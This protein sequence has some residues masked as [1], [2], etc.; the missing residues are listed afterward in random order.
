MQQKADNI[1]IIVEESDGESHESD[2]DV[3]PELHGVE[4]ITILVESDDDSRGIESGLEDTDENSSQHSSYIDDYPDLEEVPVNKTKKRSKGISEFIGRG[5][6]RSRVSD[7]DSPKASKKLSTHKG[8][9]STAAKASTLTFMH[10]VI[11]AGPKLTTNPCFVPGC[12]LPKSKKVYFFRVP[13]NKILFQ[14]WDILIKRPGV[15]LTGQCLVCEQHFH[16]DDI[17]TVRSPKQSGG[18]CLYQPHLALKKEA[19][20]CINYVQRCPVINCGLRAGP[21]QQFPI[22]EKNN[23]AVWLERLGNPRLKFEDI[24]HI[25]RYRICNGHFRKKCFDENGELKSGSAPTE[26]IPDFPPK[27]YMSYPSARDLVTLPTPPLTGRC[28]FDKCADKAKKKQKVY[29]LPST[30]ESVVKWLASTGH[31]N[32]IC[33]NLEKTVERVKQ[34]VSDGFGVCLDHFTSYDF[35]DA[36][37]KELANTAVPTRKGDQEISIN[38]A[39]EVKNVVPVPSSAAIA[40]PPVSPVNNNMLILLPNSATTTVA[41][42]ITPVSL[43]LP[44]NPSPQQTKS[45]VE[46]TP[47]TPILPPPLATPANMVPLLVSNNG[48][49]K[50][51]ETIS[52]R[53]HRTHLAWSIALY[54]NTKR[55]ATLSTRSHQ[56]R[57]ATHSVRA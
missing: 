33:T 32:W 6:K 57:F 15:R 52:P 4:D 29:P 43:V 9:T 22:L 31:P 40:P 36:S 34:Q 56:T 1:E 11:F 21:S 7:D 37:L 13:R 41:P 3:E 5:T 42:P 20:P 30:F 14:L 27:A 19:L 50:V 39:V 51:R 49:M 44:V 47:P 23:F 38:Y 54:F 17:L 8:E 25:L 16:K 28:A 24:L 18:V 12:Q 45:A 46:P 53:S 55:S 10:C 48:D 35:V 2:A 26:N